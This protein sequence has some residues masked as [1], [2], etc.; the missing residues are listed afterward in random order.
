MHFNL[1]LIIFNSIVLTEYSI[2]YIFIILFLLNK[3]PI[4]LI[5]L[6]KRSHF[7]KRKNPIL[8]H[9][10]GIIKKVLF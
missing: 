6:T 2:I 10:N 3:Y 9:Q 4:N 7:Q 5:V 8:I 1:S